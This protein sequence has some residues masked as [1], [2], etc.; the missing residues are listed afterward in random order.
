MGEKPGLAMGTEGT[1]RL[2]GIQMVGPASFNR[3]ISSIS[4]TFS[5]VQDSFKD[6]VIS[7]LTGKYVSFEREFSCSDVGSS[8]SEV[9]TYGPIRCPDNRHC[10]YVT[11]LEQRRNCLKIVA[12]I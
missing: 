1:G 8:R 7:S 5:S 3:T 9:A 10:V 2:D 12:T 6:E 11:H 4:L